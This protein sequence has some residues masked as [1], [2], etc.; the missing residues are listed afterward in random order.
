MAGR[1]LVHVVTRPSD[2]PVPKPFAVDKLRIICSHLLPRAHPLI[3]QCM[4][5][6][7][8]CPGVSGALFRV[9]EAINVGDRLPRRGP[10]WPAT[11]CH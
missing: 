1:W 5:D 9:V 10:S 7:S 3:A 8:N 2:S 6:L 4:V 11:A